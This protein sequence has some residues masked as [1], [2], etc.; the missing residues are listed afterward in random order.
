MTHDLLFRLILG[1]LAAGLY[2]NHHIIHRRPTIRRPARERERLGSNEYWLIATTL[3]W[4]LSLVLAV[5][6]IGRFNFPMPLPEWVRWVGVTAML[7]CVPLSHWTYTTLGVHFSKKLE[8]RGDHQLVNTGPYRYVRHPMYSTLFLCAGATC[9]I[10][11]SLLVVLTTLPVAIV[12]LLR[13]RKEEG[14]LLGRFGDIYRE[15]Q[16]RT[17]ALVPKL[18]Q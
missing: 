17:G 18:L 9:L 16:G 2:V 4:T 7:A 6:N 8:L 12:F 10:S 3:L 13:V 5:V 11:A 1:V 14:L 15:Y